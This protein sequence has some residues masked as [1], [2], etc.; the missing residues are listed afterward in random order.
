MA[1][2]TLAP[3]LN[4]YKV[5]FAKKRCLETLLGGVNLL[6]GSGDTPAFIHISQ[7]FLFLFPLIVGLPLVFVQSNLGVFTNDW[8]MSVI[9]GGK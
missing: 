6:V 3:I 7:I 8:I 9:Y 2:N 5:A 4:D 1:T